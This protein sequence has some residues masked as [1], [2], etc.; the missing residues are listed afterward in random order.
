MG[1]LVNEE[2]FS[3]GGVKRHQKSPC[4]NHYDPWN[5]R[6][7][8]QHLP[9]GQALLADTQRRIEKIVVADAVPLRPSRR[10]ILLPSSLLLAFLAALFCDMPPVPAAQM[11]CVTR[12]SV[13]S[14][15]SGPVVA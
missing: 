3:R 1:V 12:P 14:Q 4:S 2:G 11:K 13:C 5:R 8:A 7:R 9:A 6:D 10:A 15:I